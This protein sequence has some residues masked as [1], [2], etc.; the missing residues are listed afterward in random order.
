MSIV[1][2][3]DADFKRLQSKFSYQNFFCAHEDAYT[4]KPGGSVIVKTA[5]YPPEL[6][7][8]K[9]LLFPRADG[10]YS[11]VEYAMLSHLRA[12][13]A[14]SAGSDACTNI[15]WKFFLYGYQRKPTDKRVIRIIK[16]LKKRKL[17]IARFASAISRTN[18]TGFPDLLDF[19]PN[20]I[21][22]LEVKTYADI[23][24][25]RQKVAA[26]VLM[27]F[28]FGFMVLKLEERTRTTSAFVRARKAARDEAMAQ[29]TRFIRSDIGKLL[30]D[31]V[32]VP[33][34]KTIKSLGYVE[35]TNGRLGADEVRT[36]R[37]A[38]SALA[39]VITQYTQDF[40]LLTFDPSMKTSPRY[41]ERTLFRREITISGRQLIEIA[42]ALYCGGAL[43]WWKATIALLPFVND[44]TVDEELISI[45]EKAY[46]F[47]LMFRTDFFVVPKLEDYKSKLAGDLKFG[48]IPFK[49]NSLI[50]A[51]LQIV[52]FNQRGSTEDRNRLKIFSIIDKLPKRKET[53]VFPSISKSTPNS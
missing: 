4:H 27:D 19:R 49:R 41:C 33:N 38:P 13:G 52:D 8:F 18:G 25:K 46:D 22:C 47:E 29:F 40:C 37:T 11:S 20:K 21:W 50:S 23:W 10:Y 16:D 7:H 44:S 32:V 34:T 45:L 35:T 12:D 6:L 31:T 24:T 3:K 42:E 30:F 9:R 26:E 53:T 14:I 5:E 36:A 51:Y 1:R 15:P 17:G 28:G 39:F 2:L 48:A 43:R